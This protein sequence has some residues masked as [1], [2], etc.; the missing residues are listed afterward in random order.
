MEK[1]QTLFDWVDITVAPDIKPGTYHLM[2]QFPRRQ[3]Q[4]QSAET[5]QEAGLTEKQ[6]A[7]FLNI[8]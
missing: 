5:L 6:E 7:L 1:L 2:S 8:M 3:L 4:A